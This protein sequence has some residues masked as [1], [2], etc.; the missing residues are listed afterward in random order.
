[1]ERMFDECLYY[2]DEPGLSESAKEQLFKEEVL[3]TYNLLI[4]L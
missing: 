2:N 4:I 1:M 3:Q